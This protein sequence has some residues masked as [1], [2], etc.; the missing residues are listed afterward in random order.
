MLLAKSLTWRI[1]DA[2]V[3]VVN[4]HCS[5]ASVHLAPLSATVAVFAAERR[6]PAVGFALGF[7]LGPKVT[8]CVK[9]SYPLLRSTSSVQNLIVDITKS[10][11]LSDLPKR[12]EFKVF[13]QAGFLSGH[14]T[15]SHQHLCCW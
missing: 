15:A 10:L 2:R 3:S 1:G 11:L 6:A 9:K 12:T 13:Y 4:A 8:Y 7:T 14:C 5:V